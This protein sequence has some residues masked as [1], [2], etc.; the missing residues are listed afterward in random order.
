MEDT[1]KFLNNLISLLKVVTEQLKNQGIEI[2][3]LKAR[4]SR[5]EGKDNQN[6]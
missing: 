4:V 2:I 1:T 5:L 6:G 3:N